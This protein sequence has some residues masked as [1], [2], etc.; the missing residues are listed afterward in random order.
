[1]Y[2][3]HCTFSLPTELRFLYNHFYFAYL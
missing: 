2:M 3:V 1:V